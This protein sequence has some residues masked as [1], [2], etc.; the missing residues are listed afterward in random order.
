[1][2]IEEKAMF[3]KDEGTNTNLYPNGNKNNSHYSHFKISIYTY[4]INAKK[5]L[6]L[7]KL[8]NE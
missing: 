2:L 6:Y 3:Y 5:L 8:K 1:M 4:I 7:S